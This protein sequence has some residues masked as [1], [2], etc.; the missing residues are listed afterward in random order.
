MGLGTSQPEFGIS[1]L[2]KC[3]S[4]G[5]PGIERSGI[6]SDRDLKEDY[7]LRRES[8]LTSSDAL[9]NFQSII[10]ELIECHGRGMIDDL[11]YEYIQGLKSQDSILYEEVC[12]ILQ[13]RYSLSMPPV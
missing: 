6:F 3:K 10:N 1:S 8:S 7:S 9:R 12:Y 2:K 11:Q 5:L 4:P 13:L